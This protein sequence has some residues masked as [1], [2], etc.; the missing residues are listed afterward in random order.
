MFEKKRKVCVV[1]G[2]TGSGK[3]FLVRNQI[4]SYF[5]RVIVIDMMHEYENGMICNSFPEFVNSF[6]DDESFFYIIRPTDEKDIFFIFS[7]VKVIG[8]CC[9]VLEEADMYLNSRATPENLK[10]LIQ[11]GRHIDISIIAVARRV[12]DLSPMI[13]A[14][15]NC[16]VSF[17]QFEANDLERLESY[18]FDKSEIGTLPEYGF[19]TIG[20]RFWEIS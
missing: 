10:W 17:K 15:C 20:E 7:A 9:L 14:Q 2:Q 19:C 6:S 12:P 16:M 11:F 13:R 5:K 4:I 18:G 3:S 1:I 8:N